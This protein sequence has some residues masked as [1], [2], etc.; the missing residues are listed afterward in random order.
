MIF[1]QNISK[2]CQI[3]TTKE[4]KIKNFVG[5]MTN[6]EVTWTHINNLLD[7]IENMTYV[8]KEKPL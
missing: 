7:T 5:K 4:K 2:T 1:F 3:Y 6:F 8:T